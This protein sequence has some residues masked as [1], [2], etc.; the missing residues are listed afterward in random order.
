MIG[1]DMKIGHNMNRQCGLA[2]K[3]QLGKIAIAIALMCAPAFADPIFVAGNLVVAVEGNGVFGAASGPYTDNQAAPLTLFQ[4]SVTGT[5][6]ATYVNSLV[7]PQTNSGSNFAVSS[8]YGS[9]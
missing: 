5:A 3:G 7:L 8:E 2:V 6:S 4:Y 9:S 1:Y